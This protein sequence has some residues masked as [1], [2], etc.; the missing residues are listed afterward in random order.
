MTVLIFGKP[1][2]LTPKRCR[3]C[4]KRIEASAGVAHCGACRYA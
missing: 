4:G 2:T 1:V 3:T